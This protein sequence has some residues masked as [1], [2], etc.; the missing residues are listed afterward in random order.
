MNGNTLIFTDE[1]FEQ[2]VLN[3]PEPVLVDIWATW[4]GPCRVL[5]PIVEQVAIEF[6]GRARVGKLNVDEHQQV[7]SRYDVQSVPTLLFVRHGQVV[8]R[9]IGIAPHHIL[10]EKLNALF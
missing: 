2:E 10:T 3:H 1:N 7:A 9:V 8:D 5:G 6:A 4:C